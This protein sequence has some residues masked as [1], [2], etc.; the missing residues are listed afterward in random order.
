M[1]QTLSMLARPRLEHQRCRLNVGRKW[2]QAL[3][4][5]ISRDV[6]F[7]QKL[8]GEQSTGIR[9]QLQKRCE[10]YLRIA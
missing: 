9:G 7:S 3:A 6:G 10:P 4:E 1:L 8:N 2:H 5:S